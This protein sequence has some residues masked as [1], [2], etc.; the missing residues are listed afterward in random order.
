[1]AA[2][3]KVIVTGARSLSGALEIRNLGHKFDFS[4]ISRSR[5]ADSAH[6]KS[7]DLDEVLPPGHLPV[8][9]V[10]GALCRPWRYSA[11]DER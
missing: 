3:L 10:S 4:D 11:T 5:I 2:E 9:S 7:P 1:M 8:L 6:T